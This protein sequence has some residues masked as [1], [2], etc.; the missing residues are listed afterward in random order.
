MMKIFGKVTHTINVAVHFSGLEQAKLY[1][2]GHFFH[3]AWDGYQC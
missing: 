3:G 1:W 2:P